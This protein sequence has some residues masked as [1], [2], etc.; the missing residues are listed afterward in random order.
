IQPPPRSQESNVIRTAK[1]A[2]IKERGHD[3]RVKKGRRRGGDSD[4]E[5]VPAEFARP[6]K[7]S[8]LFDFVATNVIPDADNSRPTPPASNSNSVNPPRISGQFSRKEIHPSDGQQKRGNSSYK[9]N[10]P[11]QGKEQRDIPPHSTFSGENRDYKQRPREPNSVRRENNRFQQ[12][13]PNS[14]QRFASPPQNTVP[15]QVYKQKPSGPANSRNDFP[16]HSVPSTYRSPRGQSDFIPSSERSRDRFVNDFSNMRLDGDP[17]RYES[18][19]SAP[20][21]SGPPL[22][23]QFSMP[24]WKV[25]D[26]CKAPWNDG[27]YYSATI[28]NIGPADMC[29]VRYDDYGNIGTVPQ[30]VLLF[31]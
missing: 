23:A 26:H 17:R 5:E 4:D 18:N 15:S 12:Q 20:S 31:V 9:G 11:K 22:N 13:Y 29:A 27:M 2:V 30:A 28:V 21:R 8:T 7:P 25:G 16:P 10:Y 14:Q 3:R 19:R 24:R 6:S 1:P